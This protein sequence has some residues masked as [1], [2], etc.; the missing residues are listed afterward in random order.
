VS[1][2]LVPE[3]R[4]LPEWQKHHDGLILWDLSGPLPPVRARDS[5]GWP[6]MR[7]IRGPSN[8]SAG[9]PS[10][11]PRPARMAGARPA[12]ARQAGIYCAGPAP[13]D[14]NLRCR[15]SSRGFRRNAIA[16]QG[17]GDAV[18]GV[19][20]IFSSP[21]RRRNRASLPRQPRRALKAFSSAH[22]GD[23]ASAGTV[24]RRPAKSRSD[25]ATRGVS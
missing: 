12:A 7:P 3:P 21:C 25:P 19:W 9:A 8:S 14:G 17:D 16:G 13:S 15:E 4:R 1:R 23:D 22:R 11:P 24:S 6:A 2:K 18:L 5:A 10:T 20:A